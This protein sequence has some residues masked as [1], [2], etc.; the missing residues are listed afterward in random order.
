MVLLQEKKQN[1]LKVV[2]VERKSNLSREQ[3]CEAGVIAISFSR[4]RQ[5]SHN[6]IRVFYAQIIDVFCL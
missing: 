2:A 6:V 4:A 3:V 5:G 1:K